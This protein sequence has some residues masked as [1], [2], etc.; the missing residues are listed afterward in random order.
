MTAHVESWGGLSVETPELV[1][2]EAFLAGTRPSGS[3]L[4]YGNGRSYGDS[5]LNASGAAIATRT[6]GKIISFNDRT[7]LLEAEAGLLLSDLIDAVAPT[8]WFPAVLP[9]TQFVTLGGAI[10]NDIHGKNHHRRGTFGCHVT[11]IHLDRTDRG[12]SIIT[13]W[14]GTG[15]FEAT[16]GGL[17]LTGLIRKATVQLMRA[18]TSAI[19]Q[20][21]TRFNDLEAYFEL[22][23]EADE[24][25]E[26]AVAWLD[27]LSKGK[28]FGRGHL[29]AGD[30]ETEGG[31]SAASRTSSLKVPF[32]PPVSPLQGPFLRLFN[33][34]YFRSAPAGVSEKT[35]AY[36]TF[37]FPLDRIGRW[38]RLY[39]PRGLHQH[40]SVI[41][42]DAGF[43]TVKD[44]LECTQASRQ[45]SFLTVLKRFGSVQSPGFMSFP[46]EGYTLTLD[47]PDR[48][49]ATLRLL[50]RLDEITLAAGG[51]VNPYK[52]RRMSPGTFKASFPQWR[53]LE[54]M[55]D[56][57]L[58]SDFWR[59]TALRDEGGARKE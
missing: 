48:G 22:A 59:R 4:P 58:L 1:Q 24:R 20:V 3:A 6:A 56:P 33:E 28:R 32:T 36:D 41:P 11:E 10:A 8:G 57:A 17:G 23:R 43:E 21:T 50:E 49:A 46:R 52:D 12:A 47:F 15:L 13:P 44:L 45:G 31:H 38:N 40:Q 42:E 9:G 35:V 5:C 25:H 39:G 34:A 16:V 53:K 51:A 54:A 30:H 26:Y 29:I 19:R 14:D 7:G 18:G 2:P 55:R 37:F 27:S